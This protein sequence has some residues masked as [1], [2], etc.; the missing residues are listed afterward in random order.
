MNLE[1]LV[2][3]VE[4]VRATTKKTEKVRLLGELLCQTQGHETELA[5]LYLCGSLPQGK[6]GIG[7]AVLQKA[8]AEGPAIGERLSLSDVDRELTGVAADRGPGSNERRTAL[9]GRLLVRSSHSQPP[10]RT[11]ASCP[12]CTR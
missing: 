9:L 6:I 10:P 3:V 11:T 7:W 2:K 8:M 5:A 12:G 4:L 1:P